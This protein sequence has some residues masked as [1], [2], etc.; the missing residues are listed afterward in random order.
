MKLNSNTVEKIDCLIS[1][2]EK[3][4]SEHNYQYIECN[5]V[6]VRY[7]SNNKFLNLV[8]RTIFRLTPFNIR[9]KKDIEQSP[10]TP[11]CCVSL[12]KA[13]L[14]NSSLSDV[15]VN[16]RKRIE[17]LKSP[18]TENF[19][20]RQ[21]VRI[22]INLYEDTADTP[23]P[24][25]TVWYGEYLLDTQSIDDEWRKERLLSICNYL[26]KELGW[27]DFG[28]FGIY[29]RYGHTIKTIIYNASAVISSFLIKVGNKYD[30]ED[31]KILGV[32]GLDYIAQ[33]QNDDGSWFYYGP[34]RQKAIDGF[35][36]SYIL[37]AFLDVKEFIHERYDQVIS[38]GISF[39]RGQFDKKDGKIVPH[40]Y[41]KRYN[42]RNTWILQQVDGRD[43]S[44]ALM[45]FS[46]YVPDEEM[47][48]GLVNYMWDKLYDKK[49]LR[50]APEIFIYGRNRNE[51][52]EFYGWYLLALR[53]VKNKLNG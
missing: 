5:Y 52:I 17:A 9:L 44:E 38:K 14:E 8:A 41:E 13:C 35:H 3:W 23:T 21:G 31:L 53:K 16:L 34:S 25:N 45:F 24:L 26:I 12:L 30:R 33:A 19:A 36:Q 51:Y 22:A 10:D 48:D 46:E 11:Q 20:L 28:E 1:V 37:K 15:E 32:K 7:V 47:I 6:P 18:E 43:V 50:L 42:P 4:L 39:Y 49:R 40:R 27:I 2:A 29:F